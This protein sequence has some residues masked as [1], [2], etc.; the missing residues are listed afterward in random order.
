MSNQFK[1]HTTTRPVHEYQGR[2]DVMGCALVYTIDVPVTY[3]FK[4]Y[5]FGLGY[6]DGIDSLFG[7]DMDMY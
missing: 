3:L 6:D 4:S 1:H 2:S 7:D 5:E